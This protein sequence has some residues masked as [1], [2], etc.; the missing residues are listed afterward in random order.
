MDE[1][2]LKSLYDIL[3]AITEITEETD[4]R[5]RK[6]EA[7]CQDRV[8][9]RFV[10][11]NIGIIGEAMNRVLKSYPQINVTSARQI[12]NTRNL[13]IHSYD[14]LDNEILWGIVIRHIPILKVEVERLIESAANI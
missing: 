2:C 5:G 10:E 1:R 9:R 12:V 13:V 8:Y 3:G 4:I 7:M 14:S 11:R 6:F